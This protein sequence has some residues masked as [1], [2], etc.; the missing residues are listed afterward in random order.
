[1]LLSSIAFSISIYFSKYE[2]SETFV[3]G[4]YVGFC[5]IFE[6]ISWVIL[7]FVAAIN[8]GLS[9]TTFLLAIIGWGTLY[10]VNILTFIFAG[11]IYEPDLAFI[12]WLKISPKNGTCYKIVKWVSLFTTFKT[13]RIV[14]SKYFY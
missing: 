9:S 1:M 6:W 12:D 7:I 5:S 14:F 13:Q 11:S 2:H 4:C 10:I 8:D 3:P